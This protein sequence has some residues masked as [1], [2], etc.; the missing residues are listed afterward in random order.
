VL[1]KLLNAYA[2]V[3][4]AQTHTSARWKP[5]SASTS[6]APFLQ[7]SRSR[8]RQRGV[9]HLSFCLRGQVLM[10]KLD[11]QCHPSHQ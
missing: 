3:I 4:K 10:S 6:E 7:L 2:D 8:A 5:G 9:R 11:F 1:L